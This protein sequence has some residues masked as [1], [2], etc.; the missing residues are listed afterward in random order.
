MSEFLPDLFKN[1]SIGVDIENISRFENK[2]HEGIFLTK[3][4][5][6]SELEYCFSKSSP[7]RHLAARF[8]AK[9]AIIKA[10]SSLDGIKPYYKE[11]EILNTQ[12]GNP[13]VNLINYNEKFNVKISLS[14]CEDKA[15][16]FATAY[17]ISV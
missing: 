10:L 9:E 16:A 11:I 12:D 6:P 8:C 7:A 13:Y 1:F 2:A 15:I 14:H 4:F 17:Y 3:I 5:T